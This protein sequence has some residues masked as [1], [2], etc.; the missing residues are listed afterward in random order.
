MQSQKLA[1]FL[2]AASLLQA[3]WSC[4]SAPPPAS[5]ATWSAPLEW[6]KPD[7]LPPFDFSPRTPQSLTQQSSLVALAYYGFGDPASSPQAT[8]VELFWQ[9][10]NYLKQ[11]QFA[12]LSL[13]EAQR[14]LQQNGSDR[15]VVITIEGWSSPLENILKELSAKNLPVTWFLNSQDLKIPEV[16][17]LIDEYKKNP[18]IALGLRGTGIGGQLL[19]EKHLLARHWG[20]APL[21]YSYPAGEAPRS[22]IDALK[23]AGIP[24]GLTHFSGAIG[25]ETDPLQWPRFPLNNKFGALL[26]PTGNG[27]E[28]RVHSL[29]LELKSLSPERLPQQQRHFVGITT[30]IHDARPLNCFFNGTPVAR[31]IRTAKNEHFE[32]SMKNWG[33]KYEINVQKMPPEV[34][35]LRCTLL[36]MP[37]NDTTP[38]RFYWGTIPL[39][40]E[41]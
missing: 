11:H 14:R 4:A 36:A 27:F 5:Q 13:N 7:A 28:V 35:L 2:I 16:A 37:G 17:K 19:P 30:R 34:P 38:P 33:H 1:H 10:I 29:P 12:I 20:S 31:I 41:P 8:P 6:S 21:A 40:K 18:L 23:N 22:V 15:Q 3:L 25:P 24:L 32:A 26:G 9:Q 39:T